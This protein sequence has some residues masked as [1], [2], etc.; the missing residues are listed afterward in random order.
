MFIDHLC[1][2][3]VKYLLIPYIILKLDICIFHVNMLCIL[4]QI[5]IIL[6]YICYKHYYTLIA[7]ILFIHDSFFDFKINLLT[8]NN[9]TGGYIVIYTCV[10]I[11]YLSWIYPL[12][13]SPSSSSPFLEQFQHVLFFYFHIWIHIISPIFTLSLCPTPTHWYPPTERSI[14]PSCTSSFFK[15][16]LMVQAGDLST[17]GLYICALAKLVLPGY[18]LIL[19]HYVPRIFNNL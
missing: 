14:L 17:S 9:C 6:R 5:L 13:C 11:M 2:L 16:I 18:L 1:F 19:Y 4:Y 15:Y 3:S 8:Y 12:H 10:L 7:C